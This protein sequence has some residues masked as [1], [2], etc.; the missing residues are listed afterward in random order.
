MDSTDEDLVSALR[1]D[2]RASLATLAA[3]LELSR[4][5]IRARLERLLARGDILGFTAVLKSDTQT[6]PVRG[7]MMILIEGR[8]TERVIRQLGAMPAVES[9]HTT[10]GKWDLIVE[11]G[12]ESLVE[13]DEILRRIR[14]LDGVASSETNLLL[15]SRKLGRPGTGGP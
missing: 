11:I 3:T 9:V 14:L 1:K 2:G 4:A 15:A 10:N 6:A 12:T 13:F 7:L 5:T 8:G